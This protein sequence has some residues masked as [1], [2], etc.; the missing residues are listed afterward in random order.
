MKR[1]TFQH[2]LLGISFLLLFAPSSVQ[3]NYAFSV[4]SFHQAVQNL[5]TPNQLVDFLQDN[6]KFTEDH[7][8]FGS[9]D[10]W[11]APQEFWDRKAGD[12]EDFALFAQYVLN[13]HNVE[14]HVVSFYGPGGFAHTI[15]VYR[16]KG[17][18]NVI[19]EDRLYLYRSKT[20]EEALSR[21]YPSWTWGAF[22]EKRGTRGWM[23]QRIENPTSSV[24]F[25][26]KWPDFSF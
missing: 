6:F 15:A 19:N 23:V 9:V 18:Y 3:A 20:I 14:T 17:R 13:Q 12:C 2:K 10:Y 24:G 8:L 11:Q 7:N 16:E 22:A 5:N 21:V 25:S 26:N 4:T 1:K